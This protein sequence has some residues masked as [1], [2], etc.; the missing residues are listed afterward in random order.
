[1]SQQRSGPIIVDDNM[2]IEYIVTNAE[3]YDYLL[4]MSIIR[5]LR[6]LTEK[7]L[8]N[9]KKAGGLR[10]K[11]RNLSFNDETNR[12]LIERYN[13]WRPRLAHLASYSIGEDNHMIVSF[14]IDHGNEINHVSIDMSDIFDRV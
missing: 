14:P 5:A 11:L 6:W 2:K 10:K 8:I 3:D 7:V 1:M 13:Y 4:K 12:Y 9:K